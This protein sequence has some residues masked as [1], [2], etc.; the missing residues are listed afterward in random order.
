M[1]RFGLGLAAVIVVLD[2]LTKAWVVSALDSPGCGEGAENFY[3]G[4]KVTDFFNIVVVCNRGISF[5]LFNEA[6]AWGPIILIGIAVAI[7]VFLVFWL[8]QAQIQ[9]VA[10]AIGL[11]LGGAIGNVIDRI[12]YGAV[13]DFLD[14]HAYGFH[15]PAFNVADSAITVGVA[16]VLIDALFE[17]RRNAI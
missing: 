12:R 11:I 15:W 17:K 3:R 7:S 16:L 4:T 13:V 14:F 9:L 1:M 10:A 5:G 6:S 8:R 2:Q